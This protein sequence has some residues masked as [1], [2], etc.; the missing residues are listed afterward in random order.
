METEFEIN[1][2]S[3][4]INIPV[5][6]NGEGPF[7]VTL[8]TGAVATTL[9]IA[10]AKK[11][12]IEINEDPKGKYRA[13]GHD[14]HL[15]NLDEFEVAS[16]HRK[17]EEII[18]FADHSI[19]GSDPKS[20]WGNIG[21]STLKDY[22]LSINYQKKTLSLVESD[23]KVKDTE[24]WIP[25]E[26]VKDTHL[27]GVKVKINEKGPFQLVLDTGSP[28]VALT[29]SLAEEMGLE[30]GD[31]GPMVKGLGGMTQAYFA[32]LEQ[33]SVGDSNQVNM[34][35]LVLDL[36]AVSRRGK[37]LP[38]GILGA[39][40]LNKYEVVIDYPNMKLALLSPTKD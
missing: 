8:D 36:S 28:I 12:D 13:M 24:S 21:H 11:L 2:R 39:S 5:H 34:N 37:S 18:V 35:G 25:F 14:Y 4:H 27:I 3:G 31:S 10:L 23:T 19:L 33:I 38:N 26:Y 22:V 7:R 32:N 29:P 16:I 17:N 1:P 40:F 20:L 30:L 15:A 6:V 9:S